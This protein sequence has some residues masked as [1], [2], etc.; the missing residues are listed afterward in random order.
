MGTRRRNIA[1]DRKDELR[2]MLETRR[3][4]LTEQLR[5]QMRDVR[6]AAEDRVGPNP[7]D[8]SEEDTQSDI[9]LALIQMASET[10]RAIDAAL[11]RL[12]QGKYGNCAEC[13]GP[14]ADGRLRA[15]PFAVR[16]KDCEETREETAG[17]RRAPATRHDYGTLLDGD[18][19]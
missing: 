5:G 16:C 3:Q 9:D 14:I 6:A 19:S 4:E 10:L 1:T 17:R 15:M 8:M 2:H 13:G 18:Y 12:E 11:G 7:E